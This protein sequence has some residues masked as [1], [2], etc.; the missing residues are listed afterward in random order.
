MHGFGL[1]SVSCLPVCLSVIVSVRASVRLSLCPSVGW[2]VCVGRSVC[3]HIM[4]HCALYG[5]LL[6]FSLLSGCLCLLRVQVRTLDLDLD[7]CNRDQFF[8]LSVALFQYVVLFVYHQAEKIPFCDT[9]AQVIHGGPRT[10]RCIFMPRVTSTVIP[11][12]QTCTVYSR[13][14]DTKRVAARN[15]QPMVLLRTPNIHVSRLDLN[16]ALGFCLGV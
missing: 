3:L 2:S 16:A 10:L 5:V 15:Y 11:V 14:C 12:Y 6:L 4:S 1:L 13:R 8:C 9:I 7:S